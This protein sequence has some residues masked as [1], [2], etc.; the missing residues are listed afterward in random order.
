MLKTIIAVLSLSPIWEWLTL[1]EKKNAVKY[2]IRENRKMVQYQICLDRKCSFAKTE[3]HGSFKEEQIMGI[4]ELSA[5]CHLP[6]DGPLGTAWRLRG[7]Q[8]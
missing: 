7:R 8:R 1:S 2:V 6:A 3:N 4:R 5:P